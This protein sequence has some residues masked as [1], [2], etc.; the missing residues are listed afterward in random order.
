[1]REQS[2]AKEYNI[3]LQRLFVE[4][5][6]QDK[7]LFSR[8]N[9]IIDPL[10][11][12]RELRKGVE[13]IQ[14]H[15][16]GYS[17]LPTREQILAATGIELQELKDVDERHQKWFIDEFEKMIVNMGLNMDMFYF[18]VGTSNL[19]DLIPDTKKYNFY[20][21]DAIITSTAIKIKNLKSQPNFTLGYKTE[22]IDDIEID[23]IRN[24]HFICFSLLLPR[25]M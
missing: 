23:K 3:D 12:D 5:L 20:F 10:Y 4:F 25:K 16:S 6:A 7:D 2:Q 1:M 15:A 24:K 8:V 21:E 19:Y 9:G 14:E 13:F 22:W 17:A 18:F 11:F